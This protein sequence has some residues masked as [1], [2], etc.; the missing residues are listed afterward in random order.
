MHIR[1][2]QFPSD[3]KAVVAIIREYAAWLDIDMGFQNFD[4]E[5]A[6]IDSKYCLPSGSLWVVQNGENLVG[7]IGFR[8]LDDGAA[9]SSACT[10]NPLFVASSWAANCCALSSTLPA[11]WA[12]SDWC[13]TLCRRLQPRMGCTNISVSGELRLTTLVPPWPLHFLS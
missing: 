10:C 11:A 13:W 1:E 8:H 2:A 7:C 5:M 3:Q 12:T 4:E 6:H 9:E